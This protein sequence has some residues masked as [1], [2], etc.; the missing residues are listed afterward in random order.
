MSQH[1]SAAQHTQLEAALLQ[2]QRELQSELQT[3]LGGQDRVEHARE[4][5][6]Q[7]AD[8]ER[9]HDADR[10]VDLARSDMTLDALRQVNQALQHLAVHSYGLC[11]ECGQAIAFERLQHSPE[12][13]RCIGCQSAAEGYAGSAQRHS[14]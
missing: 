14:L 3:H 10:E 1:L 8:G 5:L 13:T 4:Q 7:D 9:A 6:L 11:I 2:R 12:V